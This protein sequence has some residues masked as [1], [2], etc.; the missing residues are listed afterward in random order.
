MITPCKNLIK[1]G[2]TLNFLR[3][4]R[5]KQAETRGAFKNKRPVNLTASFP[6][7]LPRGQWNFFLKFANGVFAGWYLQVLWR[8]T[9]MGGSSRHA[10]MA[11]IVSFETHVNLSW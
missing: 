11:R 1:G 8:K 2:F 7:K 6:P 5:T 9:W 4:I 3:L 10:S